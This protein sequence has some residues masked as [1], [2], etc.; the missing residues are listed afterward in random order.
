MQSIT[1]LVLLV[2]LSCDTASSAT[3]STGVTKI[4][5]S[6]TQFGLDLYTE[7]LKDP[8]MKN[9]FI[10]PVSISLALSMV[11]L[12]AKG[13]LSH[14]R[15]L[16]QKYASK[17]RCCERYKIIRI[18]LCCSDN[19]ADQMIEALHYTNYKSI[20]H[21]Y[22]R[23]FLD[24]INA[25]DKPYEL[26]SANRLYGRT[27]KISYYLKLDDVGPRGILGYVYIGEGKKH[28]VLGEVY[29]HCTDSLGVC[30]CSQESEVQEPQSKF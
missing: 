8:S 1:I 14:S 12:G 26:S 25:A 4:G 3:S 6:S 7:I 13:R 18:L 2:F 23:S 11:L 22:A 24:I 19:T 28:Q 29:S 20:V 17:K 15:S 21:S 5:I 9:V 27:G 30:D 10:S 16:C